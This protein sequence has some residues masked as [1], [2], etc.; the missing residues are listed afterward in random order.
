MIPYGG[1]FVRP[2]VI[3]WDGVLA[4]GTVPAPRPSYSSC[5]LV[6]QAIVG[7]RG[8][9][10]L[11][12]AD[13]AGNSAAADAGRLAELVVELSGARLWLPLPAGPKP[14]TD[15]SAI[16]LPVIRCADTDFV[17]AFT[18]VQRLGTWGDPRTMRSEPGGPDAPV[19][20]GDPVWVHDLT[21]GNAMIRHIVVPFTGL[22]R[23][24]P[25]KLGIAINPGSGGVSLR[26][27]PD[28]VKMF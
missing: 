2:G 10:I 4:S 9:G 15:G 8:A 13:A 26:L 17:P 22:A 3:A 20:S 27:C 7:V 19:R 16:V 28:A 6:E 24:L 25:E 5:E 14:V 11:D 21:S 23:L 18:S 1:T 12:E